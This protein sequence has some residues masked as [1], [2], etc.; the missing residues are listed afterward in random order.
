[1]IIPVRICGGVLTAVCLILMTSFCMTSLCA[2]QNPEDSVVT[3]SQDHFTLR[4][5]AS[6][7]DPHGFAGMIAG[8]SQG[9]LLVGGGANFP[10]KKPW[11][12]GQKVWHDRLFLLNAVEGEW[13]ELPQRLTRPLAYAVCG[14]DDGRV[15]V[16]GGETTLPGSPGSQYT[17]E[18]FALSWDGQRL[19]RT[20][21]P[22][23]PL[24][25][26]AACGAMVGRKLYLAGGATS[27][28]AT[29][30][31]HSFLCLDLSLP[32]TEQVWTRLPVWPGPAR[33]LATAAVAGDSFYLIGGTDLSADASGMPQRRYLQDAYRYR[34]ADGWQRV[35]DL[36]R[37]SVAAPSPA[38]VIQGQILLL[39]G[40]N[41]S[42]LVLP[43]SE[44]TGFPQDVLSYNPQR[45]D[46][47]QAGKWAVPVVTVPVVE[48]QNG[49]QILS[50]E[51]RPGVRSPAVWRLEPR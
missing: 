10:D 34:E 40:D 4:K 9:H 12:G 36:P 44:R 50:G 27:P 43:P 39:S 24:P 8:V 6:L 35:A 37:Y 46:W 5:L 11:D 31:L 26:S 28:A 30:T 25:I 16:V 42:Q 49:W 38:P 23:L 13:S 45:N 33:M 41:A 22:S 48:W 47:Q 2:A 32:A 51:Q 18:V 29:S 14:S 1:M 3:A 19:Q 17:S 7:P 15:I 20:A 21:L